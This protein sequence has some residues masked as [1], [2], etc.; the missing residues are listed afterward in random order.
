MNKK[1]FAEE[2][3][4]EQVEARV[5]SEQRRRLFTGLLS[6]AVSLAVAFVILVNFYMGFAHACG[7]VPLIK[8]LA[9]LVAFSP[10]LS[11]AVENEYVQPIEL[12]QSENDITARVE[13]VIVD[14]K[15]LDI[16][17]S[18]DSA[19]YFKMDV[20]PEIRGASGEILEGYSIGSSSFDDSNGELRRLTVNFSNK[21][22]PNRMQLILM[23]HD[24]EILSEEAISMEE[25]ILKSDG[26]T[27]PDYISRFTFLLEFDPYYI[28]QGE[29]IVLNQ[30]FQLDG[31]TLTATT[32]E[33]YPTHV[34]LNLEDHEDNTAWLKALEFYLEDEKGKRY[35]T[36]SNGI[37]A[38]GSTESPM[39]NSYR[40][41]SSFFSKSKN[42]TLYITG[43]TWLD[44]E[45]ERVRI[46]LNNKTIQALPPGVEL[47]GVER[48]NESWLLTFSAEQFQ[49]NFFHQLWNWTYYDE[50]GNEYQIDAVSTTL[51]VAYDREA[52]RPV[53]NLERFTE[54]FAL[55]NYPYHQAYLTPAYSRVVKLSTPIEIKIK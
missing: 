23:V 1:E 27:A 31:Q 45:M 49:E 17:Y 2:Y 6:G 13:Y 7:K 34:R 51:G 10:S 14:Q 8:E 25:F 35:E 30:T 26:Y 19:K 12:E 3:T 37:R 39:M 46:D 43:A 41:E 53:E 18:L 36:I 48:K 16:F 33:I 29:T 4:M 55:K 5:K 47:E 40:L 50:E 32:V 20:T 44:K 38:T 28:A 21:K 22:M 42:L 24:N 9:Q 52:G 11:A 15:Q 54:T